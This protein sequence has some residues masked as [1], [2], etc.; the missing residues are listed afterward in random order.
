MNK[1]KSTEALRLITEQCNGKVFVVGYKIHNNHFPLIWETYKRQHPNNI[2]DE[3]RPSLS[4]DL[5]GWQ[6]GMQ[7]K[8]CKD[9]QGQS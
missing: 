8:S 6:T 9:K 4:I 1:P 7:K 3:F 5:L 2:Q